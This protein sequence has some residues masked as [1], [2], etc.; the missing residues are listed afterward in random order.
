[1]AQFV[2]DNS[3]MLAAWGG[4]KPC[5]I[6]NDCVFGKHTIY[7]LVIKCSPMTNAPDPSQDYC[8]C[9]IG[10]GGAEC[11]T[12]T[13]TAVYKLWLQLFGFLLALAVGVFGGLELYR[14]RKST[15][16][17]NPVLV[18]VYI[19]VLACTAVVL[20]NVFGAV[21]ILTTGSGWDITIPR[22]LY[23][24]TIVPGAIVVTLSSVLVISLAWR[25]VVTDWHTY[26]SDVD[27]EAVARREARVRQV[28]I[29][30]IAILFVACV[31]FGITGRLAYGTVVVM[32][33]YI[34]SLV[35]FLRSGRKFAAQIDDSVNSSSANGAQTRMLKCL[36][37][38]KD[39]NRNAAI[40]VAVVLVSMTFLAIAHGKIGYPSQP[41]EFE[42]SA[43]AHTF[44]Q[45]GCLMTSMVSISYA[46]DARLTASSAATKASTEKNTFTSMNSFTNT[47]GAV[48][49]SMPALDLVPK[50]SFD[51]L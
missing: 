25:K 32:A 1:M 8:H 19:A 3:T 18:S 50:E 7:S 51:R 43:L 24:T 16:G 35:F 42:V 45:V 48:E 14:R 33:A 11:A 13:T 47:T 39:A 27:T 28:V 6:M 31:G 5:E 36:N 15:K 26:R 30:S 46:R 22:A 41:D 49:Y 29:G 37:S 38:A 17:L 20:W 2:A 23:L 12:I 21:F 4:F 10:L 44:I 34:I 40:G 9:D